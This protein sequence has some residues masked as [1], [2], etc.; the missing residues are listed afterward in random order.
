V[1]REK[2]AIW[3]IRGAVWR[4]AERLAGFAA[5][6]AEGFGYLVQEMKLI[7]NDKL[8]KRSN[9]YLSNEV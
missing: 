8:S 5:K 7:S 2:W 9:S 1:L 6:I 3:D 4:F